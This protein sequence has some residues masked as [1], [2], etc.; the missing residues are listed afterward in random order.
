VDNARCRHLQ[1]CKHFGQIPKWQ[2]CEMCDVCGNV[3]DWLKAPDEVVETPKRKRRP[4]TVSL[5]PGG[6]SDLLEFFKDWRTRT[7][8]RANVPAYVVL[9]D[10]ALEDL[11]RKKPANLRELLAVNGFGERK[12][13]LYGSEIFGAFEAFQKGARA[14]A[15]VQPQESPAEQT[16]RLLGEG[17]TFAEIAEIRG[18]QLATVVQMVADLVEKGRLKYQ[19]QWVGEQEHRRIEEV[20]RKLG[21]QW[22]KPLREALPPEITYEQIRL[23]VAHVRTQQG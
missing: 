19:V 8:R 20:V 23:V 11:C 1:I 5:A 14:E 21:S 6:D 16:I 7:A 9:S 12:A 13:E 3:P 4:P 17:K 10:A 18:R 22:L 15:R 2:R